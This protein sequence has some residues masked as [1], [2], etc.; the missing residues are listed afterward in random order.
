VESAEDFPFSISLLLFVH[1]SSLFILFL[2]LN[3][4]PQD[5]HL[6]FPLFILFLPPP[7]FTIYLSFPLFVLLL[8]SLLLLIDSPLQ[9]LHFLFLYHQCCSHF[10]HVFFIVSG[11]NFTIFNFLTF[12][13]LIILSHI[14][15]IYFVL[16]SLTI[17]LFSLKIL[18]FSISYPSIIPRNKRLGGLLQSVW[19]DN[20]RSRNHAHRGNKPLE[21]KMFEQHPEYKSQRE[22]R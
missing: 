6:M 12:P 4:L 5:F 17:L 14:T 15:I 18:S 20:I 7:L 21:M 9:N 10:F 3:S 2:L 16:T 8:P 19:L 22:W 13:F 1:C 11:H